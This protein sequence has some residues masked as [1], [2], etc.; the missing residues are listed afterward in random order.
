MNP[1]HEINL[2]EPCRPAN[3]TSASAEWKATAANCPPEKQ[4]PPEYRLNPKRRNDPNYE[5]PPHFF[6]GFGLN[7]QHIIDYHQTHELPRPPPQSQRKRVSIWLFFI[8]TVLKHLR[9]LCEYDGL[10]IVFAM[11][12]EYDLVLAMYNSYTFHYEELADEDEADVIQ[13]LRREMPDVFE[14]QK[15]RW[16]RT[17]SSYPDF[18]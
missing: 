10:R 2:Y 14:N 5:K 17:N 15:P 16:F 9:Q 7:I 11:S 1:N 6:Y 3:F 18:Y 13:L 4:L 8:D 12:T